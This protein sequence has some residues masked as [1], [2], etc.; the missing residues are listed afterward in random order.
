MRYS[1]DSSGGALF[2]E[3][4]GS[5]SNISS[6]SHPKLA[7]HYKFGRIHGGCHPRSLTSNSLRFQSASSYPMVESAHSITTWNHLQWKT[8]QQNKLIQPQ[9]A[10]YPIATILLNTSYV[11]ERYHRNGIPRTDRKI[12]NVDFQHISTSFLISASI[13]PYELEQ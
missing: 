4:F 2:P 12:R 7:D 3:V 5:V 11:N 1:S 9:I 13:L 8:V 6:A 10:A